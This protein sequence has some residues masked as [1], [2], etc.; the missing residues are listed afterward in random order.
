[1]TDDR[2][3]EDS[4]KIAWKDLIDLQLEAELNERDFT[5]DLN[6]I[7]WV[8]HSGCEILTT[9]ASGASESESTTAAPSVTCKDV[10]QMV[11]SILTT[12]QSGWR[13]IALLV[14][15]R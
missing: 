7:A 3:I 4:A 9:A 8:S 6:S 15:Y 10:I 1:M 2:A 5:F 14:P 13:E 11:K 12:E